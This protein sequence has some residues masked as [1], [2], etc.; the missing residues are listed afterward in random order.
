VDGFVLRDID[1]CL[2]ARDGRID[3]DRCQLRK[4]DAERSPE[5]HGVLIPEVVRGGP[6][7]VLV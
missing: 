2:G 7:I 3:P 1:P 5:R 6:L 4:H